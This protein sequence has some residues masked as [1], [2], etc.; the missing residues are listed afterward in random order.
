[1]NLYNNETKK[2]TINYETHKQIVDSE[3][4]EILE[5][6][7]LK[8]LK[9]E[10]EPDYIKLYIQDLT[11]LNELPKSNGTILN[12]CL[13]YM[14]YENQ[15]S[16]N[17]YMKKRISD[18]INLSV[19]TINK[20]IQSLCDKGILFRVY[21]GVYEANPYLFGRGKWEDIKK[22]R[23]NITYDKNGR[24]IRTERPLELFD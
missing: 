17:S 1:M 11:L 4:G 14:N 24:H 18:K 22:L 7:H 9:V 21:R 13:K 3:T 23:V 6:S 5:E 20:A 10:R 12:E 19:E 2:N 8:T 16:L 15:I